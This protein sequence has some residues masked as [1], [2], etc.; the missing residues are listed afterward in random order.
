MFMTKAQPNTFNTNLLGRICL[1]LAAVSV[2]A[3]LLLGPTENPSLIFF[4]SFLTASGI[5]LIKTLRRSA[6]SFWIVCAVVSA[7]TYP[8]YFT[9]VGDFNLKQLIIPLLQ[10]IMFGMGT[11]MCLKDFAGVIK[12]PKAVGIG[13]G[14]QLTIMPIV[15]FSVAYV[16]NFP[17]EIAAGIILVGCSPSGL[18]SNVMAYIAKSNLALSVTLTAVATLLA[19]ITTPFLMKIFA[20]EFIPIDFW[21]MMLSITKIVIL[22]IIAGLLFNYFLHGKATWLDRAMPLVSMVGIGVIITVITAAGREHLV[23]IG[24]ALLLA[25]LIHNL[26]GFALGYNACRLFGLDEKSRRSIA[27]EVGMQNTGLASGIALE[28]GRVATLGLAPSV[29]GPLM[30]VTGSSLASW[31]KSRPPKDRN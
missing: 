6:Y 30:N 18:A 13:L 29:F 24:L 12:M 15:G 8:Q 31:W 17:P 25:S 11:A 26:L 2:I 19:P 9:Y 3:L 1:A 4:A 7:L 20:G 22:P 21:A 16:F 10:L 28:M 27:F 23:D 14:L 5:S